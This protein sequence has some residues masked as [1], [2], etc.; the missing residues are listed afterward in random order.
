MQYAIQAKFFNCP[1]FQS[2]DYRHILGAL[3]THLFRLKA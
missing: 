2:G 1:G 3:S